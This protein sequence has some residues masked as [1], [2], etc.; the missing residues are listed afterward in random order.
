[1]LY[2]ARNMREL[3]F[4]QLMDIYEEGN[5]ENGA[6]VFSHYPKE[7]QVLLAEQDFYQYLQD[8]F[9]PR[10][11]SVYAIWVA[12]G[13][14]VSALRLEPYQDGLLL[15]ALETAP[16]FRNRGYASA[17]VKEVLKAYTGNRIYSHVAKNNKAS[18]RTHEKCGFYR[19]REMA[20]YIDG[21]VTS[22]ACTLSNQK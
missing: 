8:C 17:L 10:Q 5:L 2:I 20:V 1:M 16:E 18:L 15:E 21:S 3:N 19:I 12:D 4:R 14:Y 11:D 13:R 6:K 22:M 7:Q 9:F